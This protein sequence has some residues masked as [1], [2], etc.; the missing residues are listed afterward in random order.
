MNFRNIISVDEL[1]Q[2]DVRRLFYAARSPHTLP[3]LNSAVLMTAFFENSTRTRLSFEMAA[4]RLGM[5]VVSFHTSSSS[6]SKGEREKET[7][8]NLFALSPD[9]AVVRMGCNFDRAWLPTHTAVI[10]GGDGIHEHPSQAL[11][12]SFTLLEHFKSDD[13][14]G[15]TVLIIGDVVHSR[16]A[17]SNI[18][19][20]TRLGARVIILAP[21]IFSETLALG[22]TRMIRSF[23][24]L[25]EQV[26]AVMCLRMQK[27][28]M[29]KTLISDQ[30]FS[31]Q[32]AM[33]TNRF[34][35]FG[36]QCVVMHP[37]PM[38]LGVEIDEAVAYHERSLILS[39]VR[40]GVVIRS[41]M[42]AHCLGALS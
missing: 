19:L 5:R 26:D 29:E 39:Q 42:M 8:D 37:G 41:A 15:R 20:M 18:K 32:F 28:R 7:L 31:R 33:T 3:K 4:H 25:D 1:S 40:N 6:M 16:V 35:S 12:D 36:S 14:S 10:N 38:N 24:E 13:L 23:D 9:I 30:E 21:P 27:E 17:H 11:L 34:K 22:Q 2:S